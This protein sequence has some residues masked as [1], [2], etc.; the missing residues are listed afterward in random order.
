MWNVIEL[1]CPLGSL[2][3]E[4]IKLNAKSRDDTPALLIGLQ[5]IPELR[6]RSFD[7]NFHSPSNRK[8]LD[9]LLEVNALSKKGGRSSA[10]REVELVELVELGW[11][12][13]S[14]RLQTPREIRLLA[15]WVPPVCGISTGSSLRDPPPKRQGG[16][17]KMAELRKSKFDHVLCEILR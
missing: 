10:E 3:V 15:S 11:S 12:W 8:T 7:Q 16:V 17:A 13:P 4:E 2:P 1:R 6:G 9:D 5:A 14:R